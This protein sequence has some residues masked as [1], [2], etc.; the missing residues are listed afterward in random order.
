MLLV[1]LKRR[2]IA[3]AVPSGATPICGLKAF[4][5]A[6]ERSTATPKEPPEGRVAAWM[7]LWVPLE[8]CQIAVTVP[9][10]A[11][12]I[13]GLRA[14]WPVTERSTAAPKEPPGGRV[15][16]WMM[17]LVPLERRQIAVAV[18]SGAYSI[19]GFPAFWP[20]AER[21]TAAPKEPPGGRVEAWMMSLVPLKRRQIAVAVPSGATPIWELSALWPAADMSIAG[22]CQGPCGAAEAVAGTKLKTNRAANETIQ[23]HDHGRIDECDG[24][25]RKP[26]RDSPARPVVL[27]KIRRSTVAV[28]EHSPCELVIRTFCR[29]EQSG[30]MPEACP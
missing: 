18:P 29:S 10:G 30:P 23:A 20:V 13:C 5:P 24:S 26:G 12:P 2:Q 16:A 28:T 21:S 8:R 6:A 27:L 9:S 25:G 7:M 19:C 3:V 22:T 1:P 15:A 14:S 4:S 17:L 11:T